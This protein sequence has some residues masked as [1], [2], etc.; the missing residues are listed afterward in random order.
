ML[1]SS[2]VFLP[3]SFKA[4]VAFVDPPV[5]RFF[6]TCR[7]QMESAQENWPRN[8]QCHL[9]LL[10]CEALILKTIKRGVVLL[11]SA[12]A[13][14][15]AFVTFAASIRSSAALLLVTLYWY[16]TCKVNRS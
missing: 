16:G 9:L 15:A 11:L 12:F 2:H 5:W 1:R 7:E 13:A 3:S 10:Y 14:F 8:D 4:P 6:P